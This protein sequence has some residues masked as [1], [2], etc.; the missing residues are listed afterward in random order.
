MTRSWWVNNP[1]NCK[2]PFESSTSYC[3]FKEMFG[4]AKYEHYFYSFCIDIPIAEHFRIAIHKYQ[5]H[6][7]STEISYTQFLHIFTVPIH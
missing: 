5:Y 3:V 7:K 1:R 4:I 6:G 2:C